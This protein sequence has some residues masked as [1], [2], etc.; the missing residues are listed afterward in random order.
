MII[1]FLL[2]ILAGFIGA[3]VSPLMLLPDVVLD[4]N[5][6]ASISQAGQYLNMADVFLPIATL[7]AI[8]GLFL[9]IEVAIFTYKMFMWVKNLVW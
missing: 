6:T 1:S 2:Y 8:F 3:L 4:P 9:T 7:L 5:I